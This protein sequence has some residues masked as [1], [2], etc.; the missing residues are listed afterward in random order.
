MS[1]PSKRILTPMRRVRGL[2]AAGSGTEHFWHQRV[3]SFALI[4][5][6]I[7]FVVIVVSLLGRNHAAVVQVLGSPLVAILMLLF[8]LASV[9]HMWIGMQE[10]LIDYIHDDKLKLFVVVT[11]TFFC[12]VIAMGCVFAILKLSFGV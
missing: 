6:T 11:N 5:L 3:T 12:I 7:I 2:G 9:Y 4:S 1:A 8:I 10:I